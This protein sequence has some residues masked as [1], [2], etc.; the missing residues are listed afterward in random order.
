[1]CNPVTPYWCIE[2][3]P[4]GMAT[5]EYTNSTNWCQCL[6]LPLFISRM[7]SKAGKVGGG[8][9]GTVDKILSWQINVFIRQT[10]TCCIRLAVLYLPDPFLLF[11]LAETRRKL[12]LRCWHVR[13]HTERKARKS[14]AAVRW[15]RANNVADR[16]MQL[17]S[18]CRAAV[19]TSKSQSRICKYIK[20]I[21]KWI[22]V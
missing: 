9:G 7:D 21:D 19:Q 12:C 16:Q 18:A 10:K 13:G 3:L 17:A 6:I 14:R 5:E 11:R 8:Y 4:S 1:M 20:I 15:Q 2:Y 22:D